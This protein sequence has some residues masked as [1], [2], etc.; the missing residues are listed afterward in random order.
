MRWSGMLVLLGASTLAL[1]QESPLRG[2]CDARVSVFLT[3]AR[4]STLN[5]CPDARTRC[6]PTIHYT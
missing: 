3:P 2:D 5:P 1:A 6:L 4:L